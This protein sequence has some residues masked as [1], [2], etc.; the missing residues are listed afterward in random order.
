[1]MTIDEQRPHAKR[2]G[3]LKN[4]NPVGDFLRAPR[5]G[6]RT[7]AGTPCR[8]PAMR[9]GKCRLHG[10]RSSGPRTAAGLAKI[11]EAKTKHGF[12][13]AEAKAIRRHAR[14][15]INQSKKFLSF[16]EN[17]IKDRQDSST[18]SLFITK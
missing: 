7:R 3:R 8:A 15:L 2:R 14:E 11:R 4:G 5:C 16:V 17:K 18:D 9:N 1:M 10:G 12:Y 6:A 13:S